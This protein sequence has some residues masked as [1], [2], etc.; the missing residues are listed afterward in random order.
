MA[1]RPRLKSRTPGSHKTGKGWGR[2]DFASGTCGAHSVASESDRSRPTF[3]TATFVLHGPGTAL[4]LSEHVSL[5]AQSGKRLVYKV[6][7]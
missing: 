2:G 5:S 7:R 3:S 1:Q 4:I 6:T